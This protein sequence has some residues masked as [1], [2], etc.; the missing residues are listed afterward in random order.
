MGN[1]YYEKKE[2]EL[3]MDPSWRKSQ[4]QKDFPGL[5]DKIIEERDAPS[6]R[7][8]FRITQ[9]EQ[10]RLEVSLFWDA[11]ARALTAGFAPPDT[12]DAF[13]EE[14]I[15]ERRKQLTAGRGPS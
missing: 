15:E 12:V 9:G 6:D 4:A 3:A 10:E 7:K 1:D 2:A 8:R 13:V 14:A 5:I 11:K